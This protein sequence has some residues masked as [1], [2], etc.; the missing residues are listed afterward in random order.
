MK[1]VFFEWFC[2]ILLMFF[3][4]EAWFWVGGSRGPFFGWQ[5]TVTFCDQ[6][7]PQHL[8][9]RFATKRIAVAWGRLGRRRADGGSG[10]N[11]IWLQTGPRTLAPRDEIVRSGPPLTLMIQTARKVVQAVVADG[12]QWGN[13]LH[14]LVQQQCPEHCDKITDW[15]PY[16]LLKV[17]RLWTKTFVFSL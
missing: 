15:R 1:N 6:K 14:A 13:D 5:L 17:H 8:Q 4:S 10:S 2:F 7:N 11:K 16:V 9:S 12:E 3:A